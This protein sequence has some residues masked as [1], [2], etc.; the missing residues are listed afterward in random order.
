MPKVSDDECSD[1]HGADLSLPPKFNEYQKSEQTEYWSQRMRRHSAK[2]MSS[3]HDIA[4]VNT[5]QL[6][7]IYTR[8][9][10]R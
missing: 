2:K 8:P 5:L 3:G 9:A 1:I 10:H 4:L 7:I 6:Q